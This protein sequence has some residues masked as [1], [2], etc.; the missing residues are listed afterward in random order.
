[1]LLRLWGLRSVRPESNPSSL[2]LIWLSLVWL[3]LWVAIDW[4][5][6]Q[7]DPEFLLAGTPLLAW[8][9][10]AILALAAF[11]RRRSSPKPAFEAALLLSLGLVPLPLLLAALA[12]PFL[13]QLGLAA[14]ALLV[15]IYSFVYL[16]RGLRAFTGESQRIAAVAGSVFLVGFIW[17]T[18]A[19]DVIPDLWAAPEVE[20]AAADADSQA[21][22]ETLL[23]EQPLRI[24][25]A[26]AAIRPDASPAAKT[27]F[28]G[29]AGVGEQKV[30]A[31]EIGLA[32][33]V[34]SERYGMDGRILS[35]IND[36]R[37]LEGAPLASV[38]G[39]KYALRGLAARMNLDRD[40][41]ILAISSH[42]T[43]D[44]AIAVSNSELPLDDLTEEDL[45]DALRE[46]GIK[47]RVIIIS[48]CYAGGFIEPLKDPRT[49]VITAAAADRTS[50]GC[51]NDADLTY[52]G[53][54]FYR[55]AL[56]EARSLRDAFEK[57]KS[58]IAMRERRERV[59]PSRP[60]GYFGVELEAKL[61][62]MKD[63]PP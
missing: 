3:T 12:A 13:T 38:S 34:L 23:F 16:I 40:V 48:A 11:L 36:E 27:F 8:Y 2:L 50:F 55:D 6:A 31:Q 51:S 17:L 45:A 62:A 24:D 49:I 52:F 41:L 14:A 19:L 7:P 53:E 43:Q 28:L 32:S 18:D 44:P 1:M 15:L 57:A 54:A 58:A 59:D 29:F 21:D 20:Q 37:D 56:P 4:W 47:W 26:L 25:R 42:G 39:L 22:A 33:R 60:Q 46:S 9:G 5:E 35:L 30:F 63:R 61:A 10:L